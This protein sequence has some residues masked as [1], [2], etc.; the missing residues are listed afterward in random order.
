MGKSAI[1]SASASCRWPRSY[2][3][4]RKL[5][6]NHPF[7]HAVPDG[8]VDYPVR[9]RD[10]GRVFFFNF[11]LAREIGLIPRGHPD[12]LTAGLSRAVLDSFS[13]QIIN[14]YD[15]LHDPALMAAARPG[16]YMATRY[17]QLQH[18]S[19][20]GHTSGD[21]RSIWNGCVTG[22]NGSWWDVSSCGTGVTRLSPAT[23][24]ERKFFRTGDKQASYGSGLADLW[25]GVSAAIMSEILHGNGIR[26]E[27]TLAIIEYGDGTAVNVRAYPNLLRPAHFFHHLKQGN[28]HALRQTADYYIARQIANGDWHASSAAGPAAYRYLAQRVA[29]D[30]GRMAARFESEYIFCWIDWD[31]DNILM[32]GGIIDYGSLRQFGLFHHEYRYDDVDRMSTTI[33]EQRAKARYVVQTFAQI[34][35]FLVSGKKKNINSFRHDAAVELFDRVFEEHS[36]E[37]LLHK[38]G[39][40]PAMHQRLLC[41]AQFRADLLQFAGDFSHFERV[42]SKRGPYDIADG[43]T[44]DAVFC[45]RDILRELPG[46]YDAGEPCIDAEEFIR[47]MRSNYASRQDVL[48]YPARRRRINRFQRAYRRMLKRAEAVSGRA[49][50]QLM[51][52]IGRRAAL[53]NR[54]ER[55][56]GDAV[57][58]ASK[59]LIKSRNTMN[60]NDIYKI[61]CGFAENQVLLPEHRARAHDP[62]TWEPC[63]RLLYQSMIRI[64]SE[65]REGL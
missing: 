18:P 29:A 33:T 17:L 31:G 39:Y 47:I 1:R 48:L 23:G 24:R 4:F 65:Y 7:K 58:I 3:R 32:D 27:R 35:D 57:L 22:A 20:R 16:L 51:R 45:M 43:I 2:S 61:L 41:D 14:E 12:S 26:T 62:A 5:D 53:I 64:V 59:R 19:R 25:D 37:L 60:I 54:Y 52:A 40:P 15:R 42:K 36:R 21:G 44:W 13:L 38:I 30:F 55:I 11:E 49:A 56:T 8:F 63:S 34:A 10:G 28:Y 50:A 9:F 46:R 6:G